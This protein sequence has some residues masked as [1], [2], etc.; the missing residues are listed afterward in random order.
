MRSSVLIFLC[1]VFACGSITVH[2][3]VVPSATSGPFSLS[4][5]GE[6]SAFQPDYAGSGFAESSSV[7]AGVGAYIDVRFARW[8]QIEAEGHWLHVNEYYPPYSTVGIDENTYMIGPRIPIHTYF[9][10]LTPYG[11]A[12]F[13]WGSGSFLTGRA[14]AMA[15]GGGADY[16]LSRHFTLRAGD[17]EYQRWSVTPTL[18]PYGGSVGLS[19]R[20]F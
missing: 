5:G 9:R 4:V 10:R 19:Y 7:L 20:I 3:Q 17:F 14:S 16:Q 1:V 2:A 15:F 18:H 12:L 13:G 11:K 6:G 8:V